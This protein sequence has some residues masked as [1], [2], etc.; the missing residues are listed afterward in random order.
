MST[1]PSLPDLHR[2]AAA[3]WPREKV[4]VRVGYNG[5]HYNAHALKLVS[6]GSGVE[7]VCVALD[8]PSAADALRGLDERLRGEP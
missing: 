4:I 6:H 7:E 3:R 5:T 8:K 1:V 2:L